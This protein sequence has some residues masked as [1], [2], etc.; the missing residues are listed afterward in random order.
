MV[1]TMTVKMMVETMTVKMMVGRRL[2]MVMLQ[3][4]RNFPAP[5][6]AADSYRSNGIACIAAR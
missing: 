1:E 5:S 4:W 2:G 6:T 3:S